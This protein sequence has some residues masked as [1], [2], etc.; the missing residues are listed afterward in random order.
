MA[1]CPRAYE[2]LKDPLFANDPNLAPFLQTLPVSYASYFVDET[3]DRQALMDAY[4]AVVLKNADPKQSLDTA[5]KTVQ[6][7]FDDYWAT[8]K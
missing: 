5:V 1:N 7:L 2:V 8:K 6:K 4:D 3:A